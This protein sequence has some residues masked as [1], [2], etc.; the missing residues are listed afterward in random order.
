MAGEIVGAGDDDLIS[1]LPGGDGA[2]DVKS[3]GPDLGHG[4]GLIEPHPAGSGIG[5]GG[6][7]GGAVGG[8]LADTFLA[9]E[10]EDAS[11][12]DSEDFLAEEGPGGI[13]PVENFILIEAVGADRGRGIDGRGLGAWPARHRHRPHGDVFGDEGI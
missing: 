12:R 2:I 8:D 7:D 1:G 3:R 4:D 13:A 9:A 6:V 5:G 11:V 10:E